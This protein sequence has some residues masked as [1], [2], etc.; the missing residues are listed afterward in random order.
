M[1]S[2]APAVLFDWYILILQSKRAAVRQQRRAPPKASP[3]CSILRISSRHLQQAIEQVFDTSLSFSALPPPP[4][5][6]NLS[7]SIQTY[8]YIIEIKTVNLAFVYETQGAAVLTTETSLGKKFQYFVGTVVYT[9][10]KLP[11]QHKNIIIF[12][13]RVNVLY[14]HM[15]RALVRWRHCNKTMEQ[16]QPITGRHQLGRN[17]R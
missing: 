13:R 11:C 16:R 12:R 14:P 6:Q 3:D 17:Q 4:A 8:W 10:L 7:K 1:L 9:K 5:P 2:L 15:P